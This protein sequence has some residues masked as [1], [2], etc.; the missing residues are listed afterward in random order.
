MAANPS[1]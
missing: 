1:S